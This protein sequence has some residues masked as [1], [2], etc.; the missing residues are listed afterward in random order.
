[1]NFE[2]IGDELDTMQRFVR[3]VPQPL[4]QTTIDELDAAELPRRVL[5]NEDLLD[6][7]D[8]PVA[9]GPIEWVVEVSGR[10]GP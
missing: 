2:L 7:R 4:P 3:A 8:L 10:P 6:A 5:V 9:T 1:M